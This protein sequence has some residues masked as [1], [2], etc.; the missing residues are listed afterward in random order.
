MVLLHFA[1]EMEQR[2]IAERLGIHPS[3]VSRQLRR[4]LESLRGMVEPMLTDAAPSLKMPHRAATRA[5]ALV[6]SSAALS[7]TAKSSLASAAAASAP[8][9]AAGSLGPLSSIAAKLAAGG[10]IMASGKTLTAVAAVAIIGYLGYSH[11][12][13]SPPPIPAS[14]TVP[15][16]TGEPVSIQW[17]LASG[18]A[19]TETL[20]F[21]GSVQVEGVQ[22]VYDI[23]CRIV[24]DRRVMPMADEGGI[25]VESTVRES[26]YE[27]TP[28]SQG[29]AA[30]SERGERLRRHRV[31]ATVDRLGGVTSVDWGPNPSETDGLNVGA[32][33]LRLL[34]S[35]CPEGSVR[36]GETWTRE[37]H[38]P[39]TV[40]I[41]ATVRETL[42]AV[43]SID[44]QRVARVR[45]EIVAETGPLTLVGNAQPMTTQGQRYTVETECLHLLGVNRPLSEEGSLTMVASYDGGGTETVDFDYTIQFESGS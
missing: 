21:W 20:H 33:L 39:G 37:I 35:G 29:A 6:A 27:L 31:M 28:Q 17:D 9:S 36:P 12:S 16:V 22:D 44:D 43:E 26:A 18:T 34:T 7:S 10:G 5:M 8:P 13:S 45:K 3:T 1:E 4:A 38:L 30:V 24:T 15:V 25:P 41:T 40:E 2:E 42:L 11:L 19:W 32:T 23:D 14:T